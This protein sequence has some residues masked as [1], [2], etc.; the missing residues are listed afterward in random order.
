MKKE[1]VNELLLQALETELGGVQVYTTAIQCAVNEELKEEWE[2][3]LEETQNHVEIVKGTIEAMGLDPEA[4]TPGRKVVRH[5]G[6]SL[7]KAMEMAIQAGNPAAAQ[8]VAAECVTL[9]ETKD[10]L[11]WELIGEVSKKLKGDEAKALKEAYEEVE[12]QEDEH[13]YHTMGWTRELWIESLGMP[14]V[15]PPPEEEKEV[16]TAIGAA[17]AKHARASML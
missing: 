5:I 10:H 15:L 2:K 1:Q 16:K 13:L 6:E 7:V 4:E 3:Y 8:L 9:A 14:A 11:N 17:R 12:E